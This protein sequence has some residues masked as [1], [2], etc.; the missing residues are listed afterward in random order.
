MACRD[1]GT[2]INYES[3]PIE[4]EPYYW[5]DPGVDGFYSIVKS[6]G[7]DV[8][9]RVSN[10]SVEINLDG[11][12]S[13]N[14][15][16]LARTSDE[17]Y[18]GTFS[19]ELTPD[20]PG[21]PMQATFASNQFFVS[22]FPQIDLPVGETYY[23]VVAVKACAG[24]TV[25]A[26]LT[27]DGVA[28]GPQLAET[29]DTWVSDGEW[30]LAQMSITSVDVVPRP[31]RIVVEIDNAN[32]C[33]EAFVD[34]GQITSVDIGT[35]FN[36]DDT[37]AVW[38]GPAHASTSTLQANERRGGQIINL[39]EYNFELI[40]DDGFGMP[41]VN[42][43]TTPYARNAG[44]Q[45]QRTQVLPRTLTMTGRIEGCN[46]RN[47]HARRHELIRDIGLWDLTEC[48]QELSLFYQY[49]D[50]C[51]EPVGEAMRIDAEYN[52]GLGGTRTDITA[53]T[54]ILQFVANRN[55]YWQSPSR[56]GTT[57]VFGDNDVT[58]E[59][60]A[61]AYPVFRIRSDPGP[62]IINDIINT[63]NGARF[64]FIP[65]GLFIAAGFYMLITT[66]PGNVSVIQVEEATGNVLVQSQDIDYTVSQPARMRLSPNGAQMNVININGAVNDAEVSMYWYNSWLS[67][68]SGLRG[69]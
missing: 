34:V 2:T 4:P 21:N 8:V 69:C 61:P 50:E 18:D 7:I 49:T 29:Q 62:A 1:C 23:G 52:A 44:A 5:R 32:N 57:L 24:D 47:I 35:P 56:T 68:D 51:G 3:I 28:I 30:R 25:T 11:W 16:T 64:S 65:P 31:V 40:G 66:E 20:N 19:I 36:G 43:L 39:S 45:Y 42:L 22:P 55:P 14:G 67:A 37:F 54:I 48:G 15:S 26:F 17:S 33:D 58:Y 12:G 6:L 41:P 27:L 53:E 10:P 59:G 9:N 38:D 46:P 60:T 63:S 13:D